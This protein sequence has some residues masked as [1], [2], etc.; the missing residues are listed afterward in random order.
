MAV[1]IKDVARLADT[2][3]TAVS[4]VINDKARG[5]V[6]QVVQK[7]IKKVIRDTGYRRYNVAAGLRLH[8]SFTVGLCVPERLRRRSLLGHLSHHDLVNRLGHH[9]HLAGYG[10]GVIEIGRHPEEVAQRL[11]NEPLDGYLAVQ[12]RGDELEA[13]TKLLRKSD[14][15]VL[16][17]DTGGEGHANH[18]PTIGIDREGSFA[19]ATRHLLD[20]GKRRVAMLDL[21]LPSTLTPLKQRGYEQAMRDAGLESLPLYDIESPD[22]AGLKR[23][24]TLMLGEQPNL[25]GVVLTDN[26]LAPVAQLLI[27]RPAI[28]I[29]GFGDEAAALCCDPPLTYMRLPIDALAQQAVEMM[30]G[31]LN[32]E[33]A[34]I[35]SVSHLPCDLI[36]AN[37]NDLSAAGISSV[38]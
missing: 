22:V 1:T 7:R 15:P 30:L 28:Q 19:R 5:M 25:E 9:L 32:S 10:V 16:I 14:R 18:G 23:A 20:Q 4:F 8:R 2:S 24:V 17:V 36:E 21:S 6:S 33:V 38:T 13:V 3:V 31:Q 37:S 34:T 11:R 12:F 35:R 29:I 27:Q 26:F